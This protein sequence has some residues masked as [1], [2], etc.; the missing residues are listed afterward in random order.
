[1]KQVSITSV[2]THF[3][4][5]FK[6]SW[7]KF[8]LAMGSEQLKLFLSNEYIN[9]FLHVSVFISS[10]FRV[11]IGLF[12]FAVRNLGTIRDANVRLLEGRSCLVLS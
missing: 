4:V 10:R 8:H 3:S 2:M 11:Q 1:M 7:K 5:L 6:Y 9:I 12:G